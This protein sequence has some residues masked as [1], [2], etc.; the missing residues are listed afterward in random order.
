[1]VEELQHGSVARGLEDAAPAALHNCNAN[2]EEEGNAY[3]KQ[4]NKPAG[5]DI[6][7]KPYLQTKKGP[8]LCLGVREEENRQTGTKT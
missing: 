7:D 8:R 4:V 1:M 3:V 2:A 5:D 6:L